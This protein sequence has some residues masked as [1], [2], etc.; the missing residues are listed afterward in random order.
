MSGLDGSK[1]NDQVVEVT[2]NFSL[3]FCLQAE[4]GTRAG[5]VATVVAAV[6]HA[7]IR[8]P[9]HDK[10]DQGQAR[11]AGAVETQPSQQVFAKVAEQQHGTSWMPTRV[12]A[13]QMP[14]PAQTFTPEPQHQV[15]QVSRLKTDWKIGFFVVFK[16]SDIEVC[17]HKML[18]LFSDH[19]IYA[20]PS[21][22]AENKNSHEIIRQS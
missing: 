4:G 9:V 18:T 6:D 3:L 8:L 14:T 7:R 5:A 1:Q 20:H 10:G 21:P 17:R 19:L 11:E 22:H 12:Q 13:G 2:A 16:T 15:S